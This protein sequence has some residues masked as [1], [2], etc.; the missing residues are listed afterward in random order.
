MLN[1][2][3][4]RQQ[5]GGIIF[6]LTAALKLEI[7]V[8]NGRI[9]QGNFNDAD[10]IRIHETPDIDLTVVKSNEHPSGIGEPV[11]PPLAPAVGNA[12]FRA[13]LARG[14]D[15]EEARPRKLPIRLRGNRLV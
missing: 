7:T 10:V 3:L 14:V 9:E 4:V 13:L 15:P 8:K 5:E 1:E 11:V 6:A 12:V 2:D